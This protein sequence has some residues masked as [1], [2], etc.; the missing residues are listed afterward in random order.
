MR[1]HELKRSFKEADASENGFSLLEMIIATAI[2]LV[3]SLSVVQLVPASLKSN[4]YNRMDTMATTVAQ[5]ELDQMLLQPLALSPA[6]SFADAAGN[7]ISLGDPSKPGVVVGSPVIM[8]GALAT[9]DFSANPV[10]GYNIQNYKDDKDPTGA[11]FELRWAVITA[12]TTPTNGA[13]VS[14][15]IIIGCRQTNAAQ[16]MLPVNLDSS[17]QN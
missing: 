17:V 7:T 5:Q 11:I 10:S 1:L 9:I 2:L 4:L 15:R 6:Y 13:I 3:G 8:Q 16:P 14:R 12:I